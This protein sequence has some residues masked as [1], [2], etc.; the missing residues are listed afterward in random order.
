MNI[1]ISN[2]AY[3]KLAKD[4]LFSERLKRHIFVRGHM[5]EGKIRYNAR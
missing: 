4:E 2:V 3:C 5:E 1:D